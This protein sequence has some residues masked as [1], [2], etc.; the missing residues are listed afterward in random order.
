MDRANKDRADKRRGEERISERE[1]KICCLKTLQ[2]ACGGEL[3]LMRPFEEADFMT[4]D[5]EIHFYL[6]FVLRWRV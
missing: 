5:R 4:Q 6:S 3:S 1:K 2:A